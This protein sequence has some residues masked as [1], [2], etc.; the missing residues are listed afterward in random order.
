MK[1][2]R[3]TF[4]KKETMKR[5]WYTVDASGKRLGR[6]ATRI[7]ACLRGKHKSIFTPH[8]DCGDFVVVVNAARVAVTGKKGLQK[9]YFTHS[10]YPAGDKTL[11]FAKMME[12]SPE[13]VIRLSV[14]GM[15]PKNRLGRQM[16][17]KLKI[18]AGAKHPHQVKNIKK[19][20]V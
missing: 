6:I 20:E 12:K 15:L 3:T 17:K 8:V 2:N 19:L 13:K 7:A 14:A 1:K 9:T 4:A 10:G 5:D 18:Y 11:T 16:L